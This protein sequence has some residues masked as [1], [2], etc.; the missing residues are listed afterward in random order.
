MYWP[1]NIQGKHC[2]HDNLATQPLGRHPPEVPR[3]GRP[4]GV[5][6]P[7]RPPRGGY[8][9]AAATRPRLQPRR[10]RRHCGPRL[11]H[12]RAR[13]LSRR[14]DRPRHLRA[15]GGRQRRTGADRDVRHHRALSGEPVERHGAHAGEP[16]GRC[17][18]ERRHRRGGPPGAG[19]W[20]IRPS[21]QLCRQRQQ[22]QPDQPEGRCGVDRT[23]GPPGRSGARDHDAGRPDRDRDRHHCRL[24]TRRPDPCRRTHLSCGQRPRTLTRPPHHGPAARPGRPLPGCL[25]QSCA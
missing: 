3:A 7:H 14:R 19:P 2:H 8:P 13:R 10:D 24:K 15:G 17:R 12:C 1:K 6:H 22:R 5:R 9:P 16:P 23:L 18:P 25:C 20:R 21:A 11:R 4:A